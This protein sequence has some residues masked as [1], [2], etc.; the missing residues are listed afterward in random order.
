MEKNGKRLLMICILIIALS[1]SAVLITLGYA[2]KTNPP[3]EDRWILQSYGNNVALF[4]GESVVEVYGTIVLDTLP[5]EDQR[6][7]ES[8]IS[9]LTEQEAKTAIEDYDG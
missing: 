6:L 8:G 3:T 1:V 4:K 7:L 9:F 5:D 2:L